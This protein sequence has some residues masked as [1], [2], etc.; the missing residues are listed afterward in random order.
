MADRLEPPELA[1]VRGFHDG[2][3]KAAPRGPAPPAMKSP[4]RGRAL[5]TR[6]PRAALRSLTAW[7]ASR[8]S[9]RTYGPRPLERAGLEQFLAATARAYAHVQ[10]PGW[11]TTSRRN[12]PSGGARYPLEIYPVVLNVRSLARGFYYYHPFHHRLERRGREP[13]LLDALRRAVREKMARPDADTSEPAVLFIVT[14]VLPRTCW[15]YS[16]IPLQLVL[17]ETG[18][19]YQTMYLTATVMR[20]AGCA[21]GAFP[22]R[23]VG[24][25]LALGGDEV[26]VGLFALGTL[27]RSRARTSEIVDRVVFR[28]GSP[29]SP[30]PA[31]SSVELHLQ[32][33]EIETIDRRDFTVVR[34]GNTLSCRLLRGRRRVVLVGA[35]RAA[36]MRRLR[37]GRG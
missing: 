24:E 25:I 19:L 2:G 20:L 26:Q 18:A 32:S 34:E 33:G 13:R 5:P 7:L 27:P 28:R 16:G 12:Y 23:A 1:V 29:F 21:V 3:A 10:V 6:R 36:V 14:A 4:G 31:A 30:N 37:L 11:G 8:R 15:K 17:Q 22:E 35:A 9:V